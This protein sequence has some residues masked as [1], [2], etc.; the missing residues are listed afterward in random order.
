MPRRGCK[1]SP[2]EYSR[3]FLEDMHAQT[4]CGWCQYPGEPLY[5]SGLCGHCYK[6]SREIRKLE[7]QCEPYRQNGRP[8]PFELAFDLKTEVAPVGWTV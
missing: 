2:K 5:R 1:K 6:I 3:E 4:T 7:I 8:I